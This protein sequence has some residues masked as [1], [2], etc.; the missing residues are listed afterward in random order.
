MSFGTTQKSPGECDGGLFAL[1]PKN[2]DQ[3]LV[4]YMKIVCGYNRVVLVNI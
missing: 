2:I 1:Q 3:G 4:R